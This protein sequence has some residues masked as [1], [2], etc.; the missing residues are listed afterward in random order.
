MILTRLP[1]IDGNGFKL[2][3]DR[4]SVKDRQIKPNPTDTAGPQIP[5]LGIWTGH[6]SS[7]T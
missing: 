2:I 4:L 3:N 6:W 5:S 1:K 7:R